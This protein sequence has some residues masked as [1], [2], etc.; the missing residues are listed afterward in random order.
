MD[1]GVGVEIPCSGNKAG[2]SDCGE[3]DSSN[4]FTQAPVA[5]MAKGGIPNWK[6]W[7]TLEVT[8]V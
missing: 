7:T 4:L 3:T 6:I 5:L 1:L 2:A 8:V